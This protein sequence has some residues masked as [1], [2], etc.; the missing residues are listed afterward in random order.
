MHKIEA[1]VLRC[2]E[3]RETSLILTAFSQEQG[4]IQ[5]LMKGVRGW[6]AAV[7]GYIEPLT[8]QAMIF[9]ERRRSKVG[10]IG[11]CDLL[12][13]FYPLRQDLARLSYASFCLD[14]V[15]AMT[16]SS[17][18]QPQVFNLLLNALRALEKAPTP[19]VIARFLELQ[20]LKAHGTLPDLGG[21]G[22]SPGARLSAERILDTPPEGAQRLRLNRAVET[23]LRAK[24]GMLIH[25]ATERPL[26][27]EAF[28]EAVVSA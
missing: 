23:E 25:S 9:Y 6:R 28:L 19:S 27:S 17:E 4:K 3:I 13:G 21:L 12:E 1:I 11:S 5:G 18:P 20:L 16:E 26:K 14:L 24:L 7:P 15:D 22:F 8:R 10:L 2:Q